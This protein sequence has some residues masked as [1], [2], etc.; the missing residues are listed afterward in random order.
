MAVWMFPGQGSQQRGMGAE[1]FARYPQLVAE[2]DALLGYSV[3]RLCLEDPGGRLR[4][5][6]Y[7]QPAL[8]VVEALAYLDRLD[9][10]PPP[11][12]LAGHSLGEYAAL[13][14]AGSFDFGTGLRLVVRRGEL[15]AQAQ[16][17]GMLAVL[18]PVAARIGEVAARF[19]AADVDVA[20]DNTDEQVVLSGPSAS[21]AAL[22]AHVRELGG[23]SVT[24]NV[25]AA[26]HSRQMVEAA[27]GF[28]KYLAD[29]ELVDPRVPVLS[30]VTGRPYP[31]GGLR[32]LLAE[33]MCGPVRW[34]QSMR[35]VLEHGETTAVEIGP[36]TVLTGFWRAAERSYAAVPH[37][38][39]TAPVVS[40]ARENRAEVRETWGPQRLGSAGFRADYGVRY[41]YLCGAMY[42]GIAS[43]D[44]VIR[45]GRAGLMGYFGAGG[46]RPE[47][48]EAELTRIKRELGRDGR[49]GM[50]LLCTL[51]NPQLEQA[52][53]ELYLRHGVRYVEAAAYPQLTEALVQYRFTGAHRDRAGRAVAVNHVL[54]KVSRPEVATAFLSPPP[55][56]LLDRLVERGKLSRAEADAAA[57]LPVSGELCVES[58]SGGHTDGGVALILLPSMLRLRDEVAARHGYPGPIRVGAAG[59][60]GTPEALAA[61]FLLGADFAVTGSVNQCT[62]EAGTSEAVKDLLAGLDVQDTTYAPAGDLF[63]LGARVQVARKG[64]LF[65]ARANRLYQ[66]YRQY[67]ALEEI[68]P[69]TRA[70]LERDYFGRP[71]GEVWSE[72]RDYLAERH[73][74]ELERAQRDPRRRMALVFRWYFRRSSRAALDGDPG[75]RVD[76]QIHCGPALG[77]F[78]RW[79][80]GTELERWRDRHVDVVAERLMTAAADCLRDRLAAVGSGV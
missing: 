48:I 62:V 55:A 36:G 3:R 61:V 16:G 10:E 57:E 77:A 50:N 41:A 79:A 60:L 65:A 39:V 73:P 17:G 63:E 26:F 34:K 46:L 44:L 1:L 49:Y 67:G 21:L 9:R 15:M 22:A 74:E 71:L 5:T 56:A 37:V 42:H 13:F 29:A 53:V 54:A 4:D 40:A 33:Q 14:A 12:L 70:T 31:P 23:R 52:V 66:V 19:G 7:T 8:Y 76:Y 69:A 30:N 59:G 20:N 64:T 6:R 35:W 45:M 32:D 43:S 25:S 28:A 51:D 78:N 80:L 2:A 72:T 11:T 47:R 58:D 18:G 68:D 27:E 24:L 75:G 38:S